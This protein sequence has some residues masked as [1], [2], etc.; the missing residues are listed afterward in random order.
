[1]YGCKK[2]LADATTKYCSEGCF[3]NY[4]PVTLTGGKVCVE[5]PEFLTQGVDIYSKT[6]LAVDTELTASTLDANN[7]FTVAPI[8]PNCAENYLPVVFENDNQMCIN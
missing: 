3:G 1:M 7:L 2:R 8:Y 6:D 5:W 4:L